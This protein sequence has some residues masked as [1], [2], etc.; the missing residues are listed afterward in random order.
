MEGLRIEFLNVVK[1]IGALGGIPMFNSNLHA[2]LVP[3][4]IPLQLGYNS[5]VTWPFCTSSAA[6]FHMIH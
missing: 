3:S 6:Q 4:V 5:E 1:G 2:N